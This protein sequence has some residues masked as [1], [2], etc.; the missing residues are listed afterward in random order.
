MRSHGVEPS[1]VTKVLMSHLHKDHA[2]GIQRMDEKTGTPVLSFPNAT[3]YVNEKELEY[4]FSEDGKSYQ[5]ADFSLL[6]EA[7]NVVMTSGKGAIN[8]V[9]RY[10]MTG[11]HS[12]YHQVFW[13]QEGPDV[14]F[15]GGDVAPQLSHIRSRFIAKYDYDGRR[16]MELRQRYVEQGTPERWTFLFYHDIKTPSIRLG[17]SGPAA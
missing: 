7:P 12:P 4:G 11:G 10:E 1:E 17:N 2:G 5:A 14:I 16:S 9:I 15:F 8:E 3:Y 6:G 13:I